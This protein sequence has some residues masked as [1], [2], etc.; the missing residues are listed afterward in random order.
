MLGC[1]N[2]LPVV[3]QDTDGTP[4]STSGETSAL[5]ADSSESTDGGQTTEPGGPGCGNGIVEAG[6]TCDER[7]ESAECNADC[8]DVVCGDGIIN[9]T[10][11]EVCDGAML[12]GETCESQGFTVGELACNGGCTY[13]T[14]ACSL[15]P[16]VPVLEL[17]VSAIKRFDF[18]WGEDP[19]ADYYQ[20]EERV[21]ADDAFVQLGDD[22]VGE[23]VSHE[24]P[25]HLRAGAGYRLRA[26]NDGGCVESAVVNVTGTLDTAIGFFKASNT[27]ADDAFGGRVA[28]S[29]DG[30]TLAIAAA[31]EDSGAS[32]IDG[33]QADDSAED[34]GA[35]YV[36]VRDGP[37]VW[38]QQAYVKASNPGSNDSFGTGVALSAAGDTLAV[39]AMGERSSA[40]GIGGD[41]A[42][43]D[44]AAAGAAYVFVRDRT[45]AWSQQAYVKA[46]N[47]AVGQSFGAAVSL[48]GDGNVLAVGAFGESS[49]AT[50]VNGDQSDT[51][52]GSAGAVY[53]FDR[54][55][56]G[57][58]SQSAYVKASNPDMLDRFGLEVA[59][60]GDGETLAVGARTEDSN[61][62][63]IGGDES[64][65]ASMDSGAV[66]VFHREGQMSWSQQA[67]IKP[68]NTDPGDWFGRDV[69][70]SGDGDTLAVA[71]MLEDSSATGVGGNRADNTVEGSGAVYVFD[72]DGEGTWSQQEYLKAFNSAPN[73]NFGVAVSLSA[74]GNVLA[75][76]AVNDNSWAVGIDGD[77][78]RDTAASAGAAYVFERDRGG[79]SPTAYVKATNTD[80]G[81]RFGIDLA[82]SG[83]GET[84]AVGAIQ[85]ASD[86]T[87]VGGPQGNNNATQAGA[88]YLY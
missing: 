29:A 12:S 65:D 83:D 31:C 37:G 16:A 17:S 19:E 9:E 80:A 42:N 53:L 86:A 26:C 11:G 81:D 63:E 32:G 59:L 46:S 3:T 56:L 40:V 5:T 8:T 44:V 61:S 67:Y 62:T 74:D 7:G 6:E 33:G 52:I 76:G 75:A 79:W 78:A 28:L 49:N 24:M 36:F 57:D 38:S 18:S 60:S 85:E 22:V 87:G 84:L 58:W 14:T 70:L 43:D 1:A 50:G 54:D 21:T 48:S 72:R 30:N 2:P 4:A 47:T 64:N 15:L 51:S 66:Y 23:S 55:G 25:L 35:V 13:D 88:V 77:D 45:G 27:D 82:L 69:A 73:W 20:L 39:G 71:A 10:A 68:S 41:E 34:A